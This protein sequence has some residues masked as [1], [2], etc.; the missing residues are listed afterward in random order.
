MK[1]PFVFT[2]SAS[3]RCHT[4]PLCLEPGTAEQERSQFTTF[5]HIAHI[6]SDPMASRQA[7]LELTRVRYA[8]TPSFGS[9]AKRKAGSEARLPG[10]GTNVDDYLVRLT[11]AGTI[12]R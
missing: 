6:I 12:A 4:T 11:L 10:C 3:L 7:H 1:T 9:S 5:S 2:Q 8:S